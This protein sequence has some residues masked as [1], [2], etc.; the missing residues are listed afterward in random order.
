MVHH[1]IWDYDNATAPK[2][3]TV[4]HDGKTVDVV[5]QAGKTGLP[6]RVRSRDRQAALADRRATG[7]AVR[8]AGRGDV[9]DAAVPD[10]AAAVRAPEVHREGSQP[11]HRR[12]GRARASPRG[13]PWRAQRRACSRRLVCAPRSRCRA[14]TA[15]AN[16]GG[17]AVDPEHGT[18]IVVSKDFPS[19]LKLE[20]GG[21]NASAWRGASASQPPTATV[22][23]AGRSEIGAIQERLRLHHHEQRSLRHRA[24]VDDDDRVRP[25]RRHDQ[26][27]DAT[28][29]SAGA[30]GEGYHQHRLALCRRSDQS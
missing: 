21:A 23:T 27:A 9:A 19:M 16:F 26:M 25:E 11:V 17:A 13:H 4:R 30:R 2:L 29:R 14:T 18:M 20:L 1:D 7:A 5:A 15:A 24:A 8:R 28:R 12:P 3:L 10:R 6:L 22:Q